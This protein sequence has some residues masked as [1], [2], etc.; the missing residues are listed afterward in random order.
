MLALSLF[1]C[2]GGNDTDIPSDNG[3][4]NEETGQTNDQVIDSDVAM[5]PNGEEVYNDGGVVFYATNDSGDKVSK[6]YEGHPYLNE[7]KAPRKLS[8]GYYEFRTPLVALV[9]DVSSALMTGENADEKPQEE[10]D[11]M[12]AHIDEFGALSSVVIFDVN[13]D[14]M[15][16]D[17]FIKF[18]SSDI[19]LNK[20]LIMY[21]YQDKL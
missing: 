18:Y 4:Q 10:I 7:G 17:Q 13:V 16:K 6:F 12:N 3:G 1:A 5:Y 21:A 9:L 14:P 2:G 20:T 11:V 8:E 15:I 19:P